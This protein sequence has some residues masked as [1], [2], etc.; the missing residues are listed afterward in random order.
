MIAIFLKI[1]TLSSQGI[2]DHEDQ[3]SIADSVAIII[4]FSDA[5]WY[6]PKIW[7]WLWGIL[8]SSVLP[9]FI[10]LPSITRGISIFCDLRSLILLISDILSGEFD[11]Y[12]KTGSFAGFGTTTL[13]FCMA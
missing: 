11:I 12:S 1:A 9:V 2:L 4:S 5:L 6:T 3:V 7:L 8:I 13:A 10:S